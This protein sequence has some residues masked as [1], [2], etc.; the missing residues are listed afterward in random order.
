[1]VAN[2]EKQSFTPIPAR[3]PVPP[4]R[5]PSTIR[6]LGVS[7]KGAGSNEEDRL[8]TMLRGFDTEIIP[9]DRHAKTRM[10]LEIVRKIRSRKYEIVALEGSGVAGGLAVIIGRVTAGVPYVVSSGDAIAPFLRRR[11]P[12]SVPFAG[13]YERALC[14]LCAGFIGWTP[15]LVGRAI[16]FGARRAM[17]APGWAPYPRPRE[18]LEAAR[19]EIRF[20]L[21][22]PADAI[23]FGLVGAL[24]W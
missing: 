6:V 21:R 17:T 24:G 5:H 7:T 11:W 1:M 8:R 15:Y 13:L 9:F 19:R 16:T 14:R 10:L 3:A 20:K 12:W 22:I 2:T 4:A 23:V 18:H